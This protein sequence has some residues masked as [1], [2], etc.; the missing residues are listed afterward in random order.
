MSGKRLRSPKGG[1]FLLIARLICHRIQLFQTAI[2]FCA[3]FFTPGLVFAPL[4]RFKVF[5]KS[6]RVK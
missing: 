4:I 3:R 1:I 6:R 5:Y 2:T